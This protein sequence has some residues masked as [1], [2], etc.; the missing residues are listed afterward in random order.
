MRVLF[1]FIVIF[2]AIAGCAD[3]QTSPDRPYKAQVLHFEPQSTGN[4]SGWSVQE[5]TLSTL[6]DLNSLK[7]RYFQILPG[8]T[9]QITSTVGSLITGTGSASSSSD[10]LRYNIKNGVI[11][12]RDTTTLLALSSF[13]AFEQTFSSLKETTGLEP[14][15]FSE[16]VG[17]RY[18]IFFEPV[19][20]LSDSGETAQISLKLNAA[21]NPESDN[22]FLFKRSEIEQIPLAANFK[23]IA[24]EF[25]HAIFKRAFFKQKNEVCLN[26]NDETKISRQTDKFFPG[27]FAVEY[28]ISGLNEGFADFMSAMMTGE[29]DV[30]TGSF[31]GD[32][33]TS[34]SLTST[35]FTFA[36]LSRDSLCSGKFYCIGTLFARALYKTAQLYGDDKSSLYAFSRR[37]YRAIDQTSENLAQSSARDILPIPSTEAIFCKRSE[38]VRLAYDG[39]LTSAFLAAF[40]QGFSAGNE[41]SQLCAQLVSAFGSFGFTLE[42]RGGCQF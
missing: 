2:I 29:A 34:R 21:F 40:L 18:R 20:S 12:P 25:G 5:R 28:A 39:L 30:L 33:P 7:G 24:H 27:R 42:A 9:L 10:A 36:D 37:V 32:G 11:V 8:G 6:E 38:S 22:F 15:A 35:R 31:P 14:E 16:Q 4:S 19:I 26:T 13:H 17:G 41:K 3:L 1:F 23:V